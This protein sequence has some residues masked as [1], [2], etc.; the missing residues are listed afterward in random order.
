MSSTVQLKELQSMFLDDNGAKQVSKVME[1]LGEDNFFSLDHSPRGENMKA[2]GCIGT[3]QF[4][5]GTLVNLIPDL[6]SIKSDDGSSRILMEMLYSV[7]GMSTKNGMIDNLFEFFVRVFIDTVNKLIV[8][9][10]RSKYHLV[11]GNEKSFKGKIVFNEHIRQNYIHKERIFV[12][13]EYYSQNRPENRLIKTTL[14]VL[15]RRTTDSSNI[16]GLKTLILGLEEIPSSVDVEKDFSQ[17]V[18]D[19]NMVDYI[20]PM[21][22]C[23]LFLKGMGLAGASKDN[24]PYALLIRTQDLYS[25]YVAKMSTIERTEGM[26]QVR[27]EADVRTEGDAKDVSVIMIDLD[28]SFYDRQKDE[29]VNDAEALYLSA[30]GYRVIPDVGGNRLRSMAGSYL[31]DVLV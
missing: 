21:L 13:Y 1:L 15:S 10:L 28:W 2:E 23:N 27:Y 22:W 19:R 12:E 24:I 16:K 4:R 9:G 29:T 3:I 17:V 8:R 30:P 20:S 26:Y 25:A 7:F 11:R 5:D 14:E 18:I 31:S 6:K